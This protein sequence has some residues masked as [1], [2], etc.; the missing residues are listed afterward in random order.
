MTAKV[1][2]D[3]FALDGFHAGLLVSYLCLFLAAALFLAEGRER[4]GEAG[5]WQS[6]GFLLLFPTAVFFAAGYAES[7]LLPFSLLL[8][9][10]ARRGRFARPLLLG[11]AVG[12]TRA[13]AIAAR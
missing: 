10:D 5:A 9:R 2:R 7:M 6:A 1:L 12:P 3:T 8:F 11:V 13:V 4:L